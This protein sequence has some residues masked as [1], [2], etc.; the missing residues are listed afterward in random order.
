MIPA[1]TLLVVALAACLAAASD[2]SGTVGFLRN[3]MLGVVF[4]GGLVA[5]GAGLGRIMWVALFA[6]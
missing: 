2:F 5:A 4:V 3:W 6:P 1:L